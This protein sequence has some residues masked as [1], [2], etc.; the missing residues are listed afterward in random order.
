M[1]TATLVATHMKICIAVQATMYVRTYLH[2]GRLTDSD[3]RRRH[4]RRHYRVF[5]QRQ[6]QRV[7]FGVQIMGKVG[8][9][10]FLRLKCNHR[11]WGIPLSSNGPLNGQAP[12]TNPESGSQRCRSFPSY[13]GRSSQLFHTP[14]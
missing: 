7:F 13:L 4:H 6:V 8:A 9:F 10:S 5:S 1:D 3:R 12:C 11:K 14:S 2:I